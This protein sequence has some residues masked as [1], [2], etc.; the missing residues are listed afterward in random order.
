MQS[1]LKTHNTLKQGEIG[2]MDIKF[3]SEYVEMKRRYV[4]LK[5]HEHRQCLRMSNTAN[6]TKI[7]SFS[8]A[9]QLM[10]QKKEIYTAFIRYAAAT[11][12]WK[13]ACRTYLVQLHNFR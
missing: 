13:K 11:R 1:P 10:K 3:L 9:V 8:H 12:S 7:I 2:Y 5:I 6:Q 4:R